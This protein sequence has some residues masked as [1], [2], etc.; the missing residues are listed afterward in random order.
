MKPSS[1]LAFFVAIMASLLVIMLI[2]PKEGISVTDDILMNFPTFTDWMAETKSRPD[3]VKTILDNIEIPTD[4]EDDSA[5]ANIQVD[6]MQNAD[7]DTVANQ[8]SEYVPRPIA[9][10]SI[11]QPLEL[12]PSGV[13]CLEN[14]FGALADAEQLQSMVRILHYGDSQIETDRI[15][16]YMRSKL[17]AQ[18]G[19]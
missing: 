6:T 7:A 14:I 4:D 10:D 18:F 11:H 8:Y 2:F 15:T 3:S 17:Q 5:F 9:I 19:G 1:I 16:G 12:P 13:A